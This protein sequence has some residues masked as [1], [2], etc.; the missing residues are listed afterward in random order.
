MEI[1][2][3]NV[4]DYAAKLN[5]TPEMAAQKHGRDE[6]EVSRDG[7]LHL[8]KELSLII[9]GTKSTRLKVLF[10]VKPRQPRRR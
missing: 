4:R 8:F 7:R 9:N 5:E 10:R 3:A 2:R 6:R 1:T